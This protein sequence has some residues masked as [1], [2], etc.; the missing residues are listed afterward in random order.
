MFFC[1]FNFRRARA[2]TIASDFTDQEFS[3]PLTLVEDAAKPVSVYVVDLDSLHQPKTACSLAGKQRKYGRRSTQPSEHLLG[4]DA[5]RQ[6]RAHRRPGCDRDFDVVATS[7]SN[8]KI[9]WYEQGG[10]NDSTSPWCSPIAGEKH[11]KRSPSLIAG[12]VA[13][14]G[15]LA[16]LAGQAGAQEDASSERLEFSDLQVISEEVDKPTSVHVVDIDA[17]GDDDVLSASSNDSTVRLFENMGA[18]AE[19]HFVETVLGH[20]ESGANSVSAADL[21]GDGDL[22]V[23]ASARLDNS[24]GWYEQLDLNTGDFG[25]FQAIDAELEG[26]S[27]AVAADL[28]G[29][30]DQDV[31]A[32]GYKSDELVWYENTGEDGFSTATVIDSTRGGPWMAHAMDLDSDGDMDIVAAFYDGD[33]ITQYVNDGS[34]MFDAGTSMANDLD[35]ASFVA[36]A[37]L[38][39]DGD[40]D[41]LFTSYRD[42]RFGWIENMGS[43]EFSS[44]NFFDVAVDGPAA[45]ATADFDRDGDSDVAIVS[46]RDDRV[47]AFESLSHGLGD[48]IEVSNGE[49]D[50]PRSIAAGDL[51]DDGNPDLVAGGSNNDTVGW[52]ENLAAPSEGLAPTAAPGNVQGTPGIERI[53]MKWEPVSPSDSGGE[54]I[55]RYVAT[56]TPR[57]GGEAVWCSVSPPDTRCGLKGLTALVEYSVTVR[58]ENLHGAGP[59]SSPPVIA[60]PLQPLS[61]GVE[62][63][64]DSDG[65]TSVHAADLDGDGDLDVLSASVDDSTIAYHENLGNDLFSSKIVLSDRVRKSYSVRAGDLDNDGRLDVFA[66]SRTDDEVVWFRNEGN[67]N[68]GEKQTLLEDLDGP[69][70]A[71]AADMDGDGDH[72]VVFAS[73]DGDYIGWSENAGAQGFSE[74]QVISRALD[75]PWHVHVADLNQDARLDV[76][77]AS[78]QDDTISAYFNDGAGSFTRLALSESSDS[79]SYVHVVDIDG[80]SD[81]DV[82]GAAFRDDTVA[83]F[84]NLGN[85]EFSEAKVITASAD[86]VSAVHSGDIDLDGDADI[87]SASIYDNTIAWHENDDGRFGEREILNDNFNGARSVFVVDSEADGGAVDV[88]AGSFYGDTV[89][90]WKNPNAK[91]DPQDPEDPEDPILVAPTNITVEVGLASLRVSWDLLPYDADDPVVAYWVQAVRSDDPDA[92]PVMCQVTGSMKS[93]T[94]RGLQAGA[95]YSVTVWAETASGMNSTASTAVYGIPHENRGSIAGTLIFESNWTLDT[96]TNDPRNVSE[97]NDTLEDAQVLD[98]PVNVSGWAHA[99]DDRDDWYQIELDGTPQEI[100][101]MIGEVF[102]VQVFVFPLADLDLFLLNSDGEI[103]DSSAGFDVIEDITTTSD[104][105]GTYY[106]NVVSRP[107]QPHPYQPYTNYSLSVGTMPSEL[108]QSIAVS[109]NDWRATGNFVPGELIIRL[110]PPDGG[111]DPQSIA[112]ELANTGRFSIKAGNPSRDF[113]AG[114]PDRLDMLP[115]EAEIAGSKRRF[116]SPELAAKVRTLFAA[117]EIQSLDSVR[118]VELNRRVE[119]ARTPDDPLY[120]EQWHYKSID[121]EE[122]WDTTTGSSD[123]VAAV[124]DTGYLDHPDILDRLKRREDGSID[125]YDFVSDP[126]ASGDEDGIDPDAFDAGYQ[127]HGLHVAGT[128]GAETDNGEGVAGVTWFTEILPV[129]VLDAGSGGNWYDVIQGIRYAAG[130]D[131]DSGEVPNPVPKVVNLSLGEPNQPCRPHWRS[132]FWDELTRE[133]A[134]NGALLVWAAGNDSCEHLT[135]VEQAEDAIK[136]AAT[137]RTD[138]LADFSNYG[139]DITLAAPGQGVLST[140]YSTGLQEYTYEAA[141][142]TSMAAPHV[143]GVIALMHAENDDLT[144][145]DVLRLIRGIHP[146]YD[147]KITVDL[148]KPGFDTRFGH[149]L[150]NARLAVEAAGDITGGLGPI[151]EPSLRLSTRAVVLTPGISSGRLEYWNAGTPEKNLEITGV[152]PDEDWVTATYDTLGEIVFSVDRSIFSGFSEIRGS[153]VEIRS[154]GGIKTVSVWAMSRDTNSDGDVG[155]LSVYLVPEEP[156][157]NVPVLD[158]ELDTSAGEISFEFADVPG[159]VY[160]LVGGSDRDGDG[161]TCDGGESCFGYPDHV[162]FITLGQRHFEFNVPRLNADMYVHAN[163]RLFQPVHHAA[164][165]IPEE[166]NEESSVD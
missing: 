38:D 133:V 51:D 109:G 157:E 146:E 62:I 41:L 119:A 152:Y 27:F 18:D 34:G 55:D 162:A 6:L 118:Y 64:S 74:V 107:L 164:F 82:L 9:F 29:D 135:G 40:Q 131:N 37:D 94:L 100:V 121:L 127:A 98:F 161:A 148:G 21:D 53:S 30:G 136:V 140:M 139:E 120:S 112:A 60:V 17:D 16:G 36:D 24:V 150:V 155:Y 8:N 70:S 141:A 12:V 19:E 7:R 165:K 72:D 47:I 166:D 44:P 101:L 86:G 154:N 48:P 73:Y 25:S 68:F 132:P 144:P 126:E 61:D 20:A 31:V 81:P 88:F 149:G 57:A 49:L 26:A 124:V 143:A 71:L 2:S 158:L 45:I 117:K 80:D 28:D 122:A 69:A 134:E 14:G 153:E 50:G 129:R 115:N 156:S 89:S 76:V 75:G 52:F 147:G 84:E 59:E 65:V 116:A 90:W 105:V 99:H 104:Q 54:P 145:Y 159:G 95:R 87:F 108:V 78:I 15:F 142:G 163:S 5:R 67:G 3:D 113:L 128:I 39:H 137:T 79:A 22:D 13:L 102:D 66:T 114:L 110:E 35:G 1:D 77:C 160:S 97:S 46:L 63:S 103:V 10:I 125:G 11:G 85:E 23:L 58:A 91:K 42:D 123:I 93:C 4:T 33:E 43:G 92:D 83:W 151:L 111:M 106:I 130:L 56:A 138:E 96:T 32:T